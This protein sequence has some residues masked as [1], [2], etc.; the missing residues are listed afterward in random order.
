MSQKKVLLCGIDLGTTHSLVSFRPYN[1]NGVVSQDKMRC[2]RFS[3]NYGTLV[4]SVLVRKEGE[5]LSGWDAQDEVGHVE[6]GQVLRSF[7]RF[8]GRS[9]AELS[10]E[11]K[12]LPMRESEDR[13]LEIQ[14]GDAWITPIEASAMLLGQMAKKVLSETGYDEIKAVITVPAY[15]DDR[16]R[17]ATATSA[18]IAG[19]QILRMLN[20]PTAAALAYGLD[21]RET[22][23]V[24][25]YDLGGGTFDLS[26]LRLSES[27]YEVLSTNGDTQLGGD[28]FDRAILS[29]CQQN[30]S[31]L[32]ARRIKET[33]S[34]EAETKGITRKNF[35][36]W[37]KHLVDKTLLLTQEALKLARLK[38]S[39]I[40]EVVLVGGSTRM[41]MIFESVKRFFKKKPHNELHPDE[42]IAI[43]AG[44]QAEAIGLK[45]DDFLLL[46]VVPL[47][48]GIE[49]YGGGVSVLIQRNTKIPTVVKEI[50]TNHVANQNGI[51]FHVLQGERE[52]ASENRSLARFSLKG[53]EPMSPGGH[54][55]EVVFSM[56]MNSFLEVRARDLRTGKQI[57][58]EVKPSTGL[59]QTEI[60]R[61]LS[62][63]AKFVEEDYKFRQFNKVQ[64]Q[65]DHVLAAAR[66]ARSELLELCG[67][68][69]FHKLE[70][71]LLA[72]DD[73]K[74]RQDPGALQTI[75]Y[76]LEALLK[77]VA[78]E[79]LKRALNQS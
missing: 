60:E 59:S 56:N 52:R 66:G 10:P 65:T 62:E 23:T 61:L 37:T 50:Y 34:H 17:T 44:L 75:K 45:K 1:S 30:F 70:G 35:E 32:E 78:D 42:T 25:I 7:K 40:D 26:V 79:R 46:D 43:G 36:S 63:S 6:K 51:E 57:L 27:I 3:K 29:H 4:P 11:E 71:F 68:E 76:E 28:D 53:L 48:L 72:A 38:E 2:F 31:V 15:F 39:E 20:E 12:T 16:Q 18:Q 69:A 47:S 74:K 58:V 24:A 64:Q 73:A 8:M 41:P 19:I 67:S 21:S 13:G 22:K 54:R 5:W 55:I 9:L 77:P 14:V 33:L 49:T